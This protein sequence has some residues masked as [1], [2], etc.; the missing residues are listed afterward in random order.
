VVSGPSVVTSTLTCVIGISTI[1]YLLFV[2][3]LKKYL[4][5][6]LT[7]QWVDTI[8]GFLSGLGL[9]VVSLLYLLINPKD[10]TSPIGVLLGLFLIVVF[11]TGGFID[12]LK[13]RGKEKIVKK[14]EPQTEKG[15]QQKTASPQFCSDCGTQIIPGSEFCNTCGKKL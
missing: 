15:E 3:F 10:Q 11:A 7:K 5:K 4:I 12:V 1:L 9:F 13:N 8:I 14:N 6:H 2:I